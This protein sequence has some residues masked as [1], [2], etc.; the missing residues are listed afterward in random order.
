MKPIDFPQANVKMIA[1]VGQEDR[2]Y[3]MF[4]QDRKSVV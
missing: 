4:A 2:V 1:P 3:S